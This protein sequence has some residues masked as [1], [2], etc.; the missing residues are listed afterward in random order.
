M[1]Y[2]TTIGNNAF[3][4]CGN[5]SIV[6]PRFLEKIG[7]KAFWNCKKINE[8]Q[9]PSSVYYIGPGAFL[10]CDSLVSVNFIASNGWKLYENDK[11]TGEGK[12]VSVSNSV[13]AATYLKTTYNAYHWI[14]R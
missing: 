9:I 1:T 5:L 11:G 12:A 6:L 7:E 4:S 3:Q 14:K 8:V 2:V 13:Y 10:G